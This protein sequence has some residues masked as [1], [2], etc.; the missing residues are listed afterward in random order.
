MKLRIRRSGSKTVEHQTTHKNKDLILFKTT[1][2]GFLF[3]MIDNLRD[4]GETVVML[5]SV[6]ADSLSTENLD[7][8]AVDESHASISRCIMK[9][10]VLIFDDVEVSSAQTRT[11]IR[12]L[13]LHRTWR[14]APLPKLRTVVITF[15]SHDPTDKKLMKQF[16]ALSG[17]K[18]IEV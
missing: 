4:M 16:C 11:L 3:E 8:E 9:S 18:E 7:T 12:E 15:K 5:S 6:D 1:S 14:G 2:N 13:M 10:E 17:T